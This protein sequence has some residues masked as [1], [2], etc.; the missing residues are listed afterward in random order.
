MAK[1]DNSIWEKLE[2]IPRAVPFSLIIILMCFALIIPLGLPLTIG[3]ETR[4]FYDFID[5]L[6]DG[7]VILLSLEMDPAS[8][9]E[10]APAMHAMLHHLFQKEDVKILF[11]PS[12]SDTFPPMP[13]GI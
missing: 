10:L 3:T 11:Y 1:E 9:A 12:R 8:A 4:E 6:P 13:V 7:C 5:N 2:N